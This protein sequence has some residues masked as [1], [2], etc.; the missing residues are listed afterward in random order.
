MNDF[1]KKLLHVTFSKFFEV[2]LI[3]TFWLK[4]DHLK[5]FCGLGCSAQL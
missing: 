5:E 4:Q 2:A 1:D 3:N